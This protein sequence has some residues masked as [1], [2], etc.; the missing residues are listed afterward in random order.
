MKISK[1][2]LLTVF[3]LSMLLMV[4][5]GCKE[6]PPP[7]PE[8]PRTNKVV[9][10]NEGLVASGTG[11]VS[12]Y[13][14]RNKSID[15]NVFFKANT[16]PPGN[17]LYSIYVDGDRSFLVVAG[18]GEILMVNTSTMEVQKRFT[19]LGAPHRM[20]KISENKFYVTDWQEN[21]VWI[22]NVRSGSLVKSVL[23]GLAQES[24]VSFGNLV[25]V[26]NSGGVFAD[27]TV[28][29]IHAVGD[30]LMAQLPVGHNPNS[31]LIDN[32]NQLWVLCSGIEDIQSPFNSTPGVLVK[33][34]LS[35][36][37]LEFY[38][39]DSLA[40]DTFWVF[41]DNQ[42][43]PQDIVQGESANI[44]Y[45]LDY[46]KEAN[47]M[48]FNRDVGMLPTGPF[49]SGNFNAL[50]FDPIE[51][52]IYLTDPGDEASPGT[53]YRFGLGGGQIDVRET[54]IKPVD[55]GFL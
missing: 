2:A 52:E 29:V 55:I 35:K 28:S 15:N 53:L 5:Q 1:T 23:T 49:I 22:L 33:Y 34:D 12:F 17:S 18:T 42:L 24:L 51:K 25:F 26:T 27:S 44:F 19:G 20:L 38:L 31:L 9:V 36:D 40:L 48:K 7:P 32:E 10:I 39:S 14:P 45:F 11:S 47:L 50:G 13:D 37:S 21:G 41:Q 30:T 6:D 16:Y 8:P 46:Y 3:G 43:K 4:L 54:G